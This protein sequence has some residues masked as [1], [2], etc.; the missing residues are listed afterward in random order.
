[1][2]ESKVVW[3]T[4]ASS[5]IGESLV[6]AYCNY[7][8]QVVA[9]ARRE[10]TLNKVKAQS[11]N[12]S[13]VA[14]LPLDLQDTAGFKEKVDTVI[15]QF[16]KIDL[17]IH[18][19]GISQRSLV[20]DTGLDVD[21]L[22]MEV[23]FF[24]TTALTKAILPFMLKRGSGHFAVVTSLTGKFGFK[25]RSAYAASKHALHGFF[26][27]LRLEEAPNGIKVT[28]LCPGFIKTDISVKALDAEGKSTGEMDQNQAEGMDPEVCA[29][30]IYHAIRKEKHEAYIGGKEIM[31]VYLKRFLP[32][33]FF[34]VASKKNAR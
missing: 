29:E 18:C 15:G 23:N 1:M 10:D 12:P 2:T 11:A 25:M 6:Y 27:S 28:I 5:G 21:R 34:K 13:K 8:Y 33:I 14:V 3:I 26:E 30:K 16:E 32:K 22:L 7:G 19:G 17:V 9:S 31:G 4:G 24:G 20:K